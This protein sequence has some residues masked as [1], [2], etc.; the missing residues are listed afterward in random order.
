MKFGD[1][2]FTNVLQCDPIELSV[3]TEKGEEKIVFGD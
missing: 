2:F 3:S 1:T